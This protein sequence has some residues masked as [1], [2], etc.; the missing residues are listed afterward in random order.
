[1]F[2]G[3]KIGSLPFSYLGV[4]NF[5]G[6]P[7]AIYF[8][9]LMD[10]I[11]SMLVNWKSSHL[12]FVG[13]VQLVK[14]IV[15]AMFI[16]TFLIY[17]C[18]VSLIKELEKCCRNFIWSCN[19]LMR[20][21]V[22]VY[23]DKVYSPI[24]QGGLVI[25]SLLVFNATSSQKLYWDII[26]SKEPWAQILKVRV[27]KKYVPITYHISYTLVQYQKRV[28]RLASWFQNHHWWWV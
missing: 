16:Q 3:F 1:M 25:K 24:P 21:M 13:K 23:W 14:A 28:L 12:T 7:K 6:S 10:K 8:R 15:H 19:I 20:K 5:K 11:K 4:P 18:L 17:S 26:N 2:L 27:L 9:A 22:T